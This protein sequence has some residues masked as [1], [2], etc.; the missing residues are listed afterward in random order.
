MTQLGSKFRRLISLSVAMTALLAGAARAQELRM[1]NVPLS[2]GGAIISQK[3]LATHP[4]TVQ[5]FS[6]SVKFDP[7][8]YEVLA[9][10]WEGTA[11]DDVVAEA[12]SFWAAP[13]DSTA[14]HFIVGCVL[15][16]MEPIV[17]PATTGT[18]HALAIV[19]YRLR[20]PLPPSGS[21]VPSMF[22]EDGHS[23]A[24]GGPGIDNILTTSGT[25][26]F[27]ALQAPIFLT[28][29]G[30]PVEEE[31]GPDPL[32]SPSPGPGDGDGSEGGG[33]SQSTGPSKFAWMSMVAGLT[34]ALLGRTRPV[35]AA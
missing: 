12:P 14:G 9:I 2:G 26:V 32:P 27:P 28:M 18:P 8:V 31:P 16:F 20:A 11:V 15:S 13:R 3:I 33:C 5:G 17:I 29:D 4:F 22:F 1:E 34:L 10:D 23:A 19:R 35:S 7:A 21:L 6:L 24:P 25:S 30:E